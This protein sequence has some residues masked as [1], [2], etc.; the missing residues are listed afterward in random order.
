MRQTKVSA[1]GQAVIPQEIRAK[2]GIK[3][4]TKLAWST[5]DGVI[6]VVPIPEDPVEASFGILKGKG[7]TF[8]DFMEE[9]RRER[10]LE[11]QQEARLEAQLR[12]ASRKRKR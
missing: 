1:R 2:L 6:I 10:E 3:A 8:E 11:R 12:R 5:R 7:Y 9:R 4:G